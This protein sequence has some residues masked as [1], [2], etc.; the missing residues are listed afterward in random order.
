MVVDSDLD[1][2]SGDRTKR[3]Q[4]SC[5]EPRSNLYFE[6]GHADKGASLE[7]FLESALSVG[8]FRAP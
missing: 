6:L 5:G 4:I 1:M 2:A 8:I 3:G 7:P